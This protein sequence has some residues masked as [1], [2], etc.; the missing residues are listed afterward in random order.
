MYIRG[1]RVYSVTTVAMPANGRET[2]F[3]MPIAR[4][5]ISNGNSYWLMW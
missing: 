1:F 2:K 3:V 4:P 5:L